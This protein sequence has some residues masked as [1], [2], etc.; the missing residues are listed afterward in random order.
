MQP[1]KIKTI[2]PLL[3]L[4]G[5]CVA[6]AQT[7]NIITNSNKPTILTQDQAETLAL[8]L[9]NDRAMELYKWNQMFLY[10]NS[11]Q[12]NQV[13]G[14]WVW[15]DWRGSGHGVFNATVELAFDG[16]TNSVKITYKDGWLP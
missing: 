5:C 11:P 9:A 7:I 6:S 2:I 15:T 13:A 4:A 3:L 8:R 10:E 1:R 14:H 16:S 12:A